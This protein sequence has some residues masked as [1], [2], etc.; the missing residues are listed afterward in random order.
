MNQ[1][2]SVI[3]QKDGGVGGEAQSKIKDDYYVTSVEN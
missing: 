2:H 3:D 1:Q